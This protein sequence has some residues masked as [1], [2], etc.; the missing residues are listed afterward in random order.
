[1]KPLLVASAVLICGYGT[2]FAADDPAPEYSANS[3][4]AGC[5]AVAAEDSRGLLPGKDALDAGFC[6]G[7]VFSILYASRV[8]S[9]P[10]C[11]PSQVTVNQGVKVAIAYIDVRPA[12]QPRPM[13]CV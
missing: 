2:S 12:L 5:H 9:P 4:M 3:L 11:V 1:M 10:I 6:A 13:R 7:V 8:W